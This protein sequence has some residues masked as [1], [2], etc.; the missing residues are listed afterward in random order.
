MPCAFPF[1]VLCSSMVFKCVGFSFSF[2]CQHWWPGTHG[3]YVELV[4]KNTRW[5][6]ELVAE[7]AALLFLDKAD[8]HSSL[9]DSEFSKAFRICSLFLQP[10][11]LLPPSQSRE[12]GS[13]RN[14]SSKASSS[15]LQKSLGSSG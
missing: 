9:R 1:C 14:A 7:A 2:P 13:R 15:H 5:T 4:S 10:T 12:A 3:V 6:H 8:F 11:W